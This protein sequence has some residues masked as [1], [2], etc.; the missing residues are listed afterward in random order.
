MSDEPHQPDAQEH[1]TD[2]RTRIA[3]A[4][5]VRWKTLTLTD[6]WD[7]NCMELADAVIRELGLPPTWGVPSFANGKRTDL[8]ALQREMHPIPP[9]EIEYSVAV[10]DGRVSVTA[11]HGQ[12]RGWASDPD[13]VSARRKA[14]TRLL[15]ARDYR[16]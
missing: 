14:K 13:E 8:V 9:D 5:Q 1:T 10:E 4:I 7:E 2:L 12:Y 3:D 11:S 16:L 6:T 15:Y